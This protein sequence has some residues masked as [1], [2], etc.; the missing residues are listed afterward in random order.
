MVDPTRRWASWIWLVQLAVG[1]VGLGLSNFS[2]GSDDAGLV[3]PMLGH[4][5]FDGLSGPL[6]GAC[7]AIVLKIRS[8]SFSYSYFLFRKVS[9][10]LYDIDFVVADFD[11]YTLH[12]QYL[13]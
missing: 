2:D 1:R 11:P 7:R 10:K 12:I 5:S 6:R 13:N 9:W 8:F 3:V 4:C